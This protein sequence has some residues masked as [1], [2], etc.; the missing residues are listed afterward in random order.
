MRRNLLIIFFFVFLIP[1]WILNAQIE[2]KS[3]RVYGGNNETAF[4][5]V[6]FVNGEEK[7]ITIDFDVQTS[8][9][10]NLIIQFKFCDSNWNPYENQFL[11]NPLYNTEYNL[12]LDKIPN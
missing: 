3:L 2:I 10:P 5:V 9:F 6:D 11:Q 12:W 7:F 1:Y 8:S 4:P